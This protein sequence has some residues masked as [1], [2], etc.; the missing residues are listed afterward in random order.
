MDDAPEHRGF[1]FR[2]K[3]FILIGASLILFL[4]CLIILTVLPTFGTKPEYEL[5]SIFWLTSAVTQTNDEAPTAHS[6]HQVELTATI[7]P[8]VSANIP[9]EMEVAYVTQVIDGDTIEV[10]WNGDTHRLRYIGVDSPEIG[11]NGSTEAAEE[12]R[13]LIEGK[14]CCAMFIWRMGHL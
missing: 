3:W 4:L 10:F 6:E 7:L 9:V 12:N 2:F 13:K 8:S 1:L 11:E 5:S 14:D